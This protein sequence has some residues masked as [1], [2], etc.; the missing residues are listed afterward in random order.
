MREDFFT[1]TLAP[2]DRTCTYIYIY[3]FF[4]L[5]FI[6][7]SSLGAKHFSTEQPSLWVCA[8]VRGSART[9]L[10]LSSSSSSSSTRRRFPTFQK[11]QKVHRQVARKNGPKGFEL[12][13]GGRCA[14]RA[15][16]LEAHLSLFSPS[17]LANLPTLAI[18]IYLPT[19]RP[20]SSTYLL[21]FRN[22]PA[23]LSPSLTLCSF[24]AFSFFPRRQN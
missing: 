1:C 7:V 23:S 16:G 12:R 18:S 17:L 15:S 19:D 2:Y 24:F 20:T 3:K 9:V 10:Q 8:F 13:C 14:A 5:F 6:A 21:R 22:H 11:G 4:F